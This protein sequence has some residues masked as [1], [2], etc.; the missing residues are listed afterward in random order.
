[1]F[2]KQRFADKIKKYYQND[3]YLARHLNITAS[4]FYA[5]RTATNNPSIDFVKKFCRYYDI[6]ANELLGIDRFGAKTIRAKNICDEHY[7][8]MTD[9]WVRLTVA[10]MANDLT[11]QLV[12]ESLGMSTQTISNYVNGRTVPNGAIVVDLCEYLGVSADWLLG[13]V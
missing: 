6:S 3:K 13:L 11:Q 8:G 1:M 5:Y 10:I 9:F 12:A 2:D 4:Q 7:K